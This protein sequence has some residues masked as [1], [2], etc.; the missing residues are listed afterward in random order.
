MTWTSLFRGTLARRLSRKVTKA[1]LLCGSTG[2]P[3]NL[4][5]RVFNAAYRDKVP[6]R[7]YSKP[8][9]SQSPRRERQYRVQ[10]I[11]RLKLCLFIQREDG[12]VLGR[13]QVEANDIGGLLLEV[14]IVGGHVALDP[15]RFDSCSAPNALDQHVADPKLFRELARAPVTRKF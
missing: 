6:C 10:T 5:V 4:P 15:V 11:K 12:G 7:Q 1:A 3:S 13:V 8:C 2:A 9:L 14:R